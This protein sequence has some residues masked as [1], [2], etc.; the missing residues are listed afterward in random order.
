MAISCFQGFEVP[1]PGD[2]VLG[3]TYEREGD[4]TPSI[5]IVLNWYEEF[6]DR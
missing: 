4:V 1:P 2:R 6:R 3:V 5:G